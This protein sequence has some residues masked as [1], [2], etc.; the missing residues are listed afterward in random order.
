MSMSTHQDSSPPQGMPLPGFRWRGFTV[1]LFLVTILPL[2]LLL[3]AI[4]LIS[5]SLHHQA[6]R[7]LV[8]DRNLRAVSAAAASVDEQVQHL[9]F[10][11]QL[12]APRTA[13]PAAL[14]APSGDTALLLQSFDGGAALFDRSGRVV[15]ASAPNLPWLQLTDAQWQPMQQ[16]AAGQPLLLEITR[17]GQPPLALISLPVGSDRILAAAYRPDVLAR[18]VLKPLITN[19][20]TILILVSSNGDLLMQSGP[21][22]ADEMAGHH[23]GIAE[24]LRGEAGTSDYPTSHSDHVVAY[25]PIPSTGWALVME[26]TWEEISTPFLS[27]TQS[28]PLLM[29]P[30][31]VLALI[32]L[33]FGARQVIQPLQKLE[34]QAANLAQG[35]FDAIRQPVGGIGEIRHL[36]AELV[37]MAQDLQAVQGSLHSYIGAITAGVEKERL[38]LAR[39]LHDETLQA[40][41]ALQQRAQL[42]A[43]DPENTAPLQE[44]QRLTQ[45]AITDLRQMVRG[46]RPIYLEDLG[47]TAALE[48]LAKET[49]QNNGLAVQ[50]ELQGESRRLDP[51]VEL[52]LY[53]MTQ[54]AL[55]NAAHHAK[56]SQLTVRLSFAAQQL[57]LTVRDDGAGFTP[58]QQMDQFAREGHFGLLGLHERA[59]LINARLSIR[60]A[61][62]EGTEVLIELPLS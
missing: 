10:S 35:D 54:E 57:T 39:E 7:S 37:L 20:Q 19:E 50:F 42:A 9:I 45:Q 15:D 33:W 58:P 40:L 34:Q 18:R 48:M 30:M 16:A 2:T 5:Q 4:V 21:M 25:S 14:S 11:L 47:L 8:A 61:P 6:M 28:A 12:L 46:L 24:A 23:P 44:L 36:Q 52:A 26:E 43:L 62:G 38:D 22:S 49:Q 56:A 51:K 59:E 41:I 1:Q 31:L 3:L 60:S 53:R 17:S 55:N 32:A 29:L 27:T 13:Q